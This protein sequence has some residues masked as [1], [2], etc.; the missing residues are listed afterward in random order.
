[1]EM[2]FCLQT[3]FIEDVESFFLYKTVSEEQ[4]FKRVIFL[5]F[6]FS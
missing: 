4:I 6:V 3:F 5:K 2:N 1:M